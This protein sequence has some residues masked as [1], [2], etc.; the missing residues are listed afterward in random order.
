ML[1]FKD[2][3]E[4]ELQR[5]FNGLTGGACGGNDD[6]APVSVSGALKASGSGGRLWSRD[7]CTA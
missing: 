5:E 6:D 3:V 4:V 7:G 2:G 1:A